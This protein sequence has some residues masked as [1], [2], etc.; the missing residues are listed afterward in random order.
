MD[1]VFISG[2]FLTDEEARGLIIPYNDNNHDSSNNKN[3]TA[4]I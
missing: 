1:I 3:N 2:F 4:T